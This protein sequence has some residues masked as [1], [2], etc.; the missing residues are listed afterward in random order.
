M[1]EMAYKDSNSGSTTTMTP[2]PSRSGSGSRT[3]FSLEEDSLAEMARLPAKPP[4]ERKQNPTGEFRRRKYIFQDGSTLRDTCPASPT[5][6][7]TGE[8]RAQRDREQNN[9]VRI[10]GPLQKRSFGFWWTQYWV[11]LDRV[12]LRL[13]ETEQASLT[14]A[15]S[16]IEEISVQELTAEQPKN[17]PA[18]IVCT[19]GGGSRK[20][21][22]FRSG[23]ETTWEDVAA[24]RL[25]LWA[26][27]D[28]QKR[29]A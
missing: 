26:L 13:Y 17:Q 25:W 15:A 10:E 16:P 22:Y 27:T 24:A 23:C 19:H 20:V 3:A 18:W 7:W 2:P 6:D 29:R 12:A 14:S 1:T 5:R 28:A 8:L 9:Q 21:A 11:V 4:R